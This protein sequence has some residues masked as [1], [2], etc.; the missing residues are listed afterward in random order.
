[1]SKNHLSG[2]TPLGRPVFGRPPKGQR[3]GG[4]TLIEMMITVAIIALL[5]RI[6]YPAYTEYIARSKR[7]EAQAI[8]M[9]A[10]QYMERFFAENY[11]YDQNT[12]GVAVTDGALFA[13]RFSKSPKSGSGTNYTITLPS[14]SLA[15]NTY[16][17]K[18]TRSGT[19]ATDKCGNFGIDNL[20]RKSID[21]YSSSYATDAAALAACW[22]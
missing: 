7:A 21:S 8:L 12:A 6:A 3:S 2:A 9:E 17:V 20:G 16:V 5:A 19:M 14:A 18:A 10:S 4:F 13:A 1:M 22:K 11:R 15:A